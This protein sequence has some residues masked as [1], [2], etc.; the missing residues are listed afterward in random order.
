MLASGDNP[1]SHVIPHPLVQREADLGL[2]TG[3]GVITL[4]SDQIVMMILAGLLLCFVLPPLMRKRRDDSEIGRMV[5]GT[6]ASFVE[7][8][9]EYFY[10]EVAIP[11]LGDHADRFIKY[12]WSVFFFILTL[13]LL[14]L[15]PLGTITPPLLGVH[16]GGTATGNIWVT[17]TLAILTLIL[18]VVNGL[19]FGGMDYLKHFMPGPFYMA[20][21]MIIVEVMGLFAKIFALAVRLFANMLAGHVLLAVMIAM[22]LRAGSALGTGLGLAIALPIVVGSVALTFLEIFVAFLQAFIF[23]YLTTLFIGMSV[24]VHHDDHQEAA[25][26]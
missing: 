4:L 25:A 26:H 16:I 12:I 1:L 20:P 2:L 14:G 19:R 23:T 3:D 11:H 7:M 10:K 22:I 6:F 24:N 15:I 13:N 8:I 5:P 17:A 21:L 18:M 9:C